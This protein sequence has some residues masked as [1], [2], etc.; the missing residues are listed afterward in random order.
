LKQVEPVVVIRDGNPEGS[1][2]IYSSALRDEI[3]P[4]LERE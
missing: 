3:E 4:F 2:V 1:V